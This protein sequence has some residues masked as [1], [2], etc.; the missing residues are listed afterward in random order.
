MIQQLSKSKLFLKIQPSKL[1]KMCSYLAIWH[2]TVHLKLKHMKF[3]FQGTYII[4]DKF[5]KK[6]F[7][8]IFFLTSFFLLRGK[9]TKLVGFFVFFIIRLMNIIRIEL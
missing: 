4:T 8:N 6:M 7:R 9:V 2:W 3:Q 5:K 1:I